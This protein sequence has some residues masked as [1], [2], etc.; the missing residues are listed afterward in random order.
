METETFLIKIDDA[1]EEEQEVF[2]KILRSDFSFKELF[3]LYL[4]A[5]SF[6][7]SNKFYFSEAIKKA[8]KYDELKSLLRRFITL[9]AF[10]TEEEAIKC[11]EYIVSK[12]LHQQLSFN[13]LFDF[14]EFLQKE[15]F[16][17]YEQNEERILVR[18]ASLAKNKSEV[19][20][21]FPFNS[22]TPYF[23]TISEIFLK[24][25]DGDGNEETSFADMF[26]FASSKCIE[27]NDLGFI[28]LLMKWLCPE[29]VDIGYSFLKVISIAMEI[30]ISEKNLEGWLK[31][32]ICEM[33]LEENDPADIILL[34][35]MILVC[36]KIEELQ[37]I[38]RKTLPESI[39]GYHVRSKIEKIKA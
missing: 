23:K 10:K 28:D 18:A 9:K 26:V 17:L 36:T 11:Q 8:E 29:K 35:R 16:K 37:I 2:K 1:T 13:E 7:N 38:E 31:M 4:E 30:P 19:Y 22:N 20:R 27:H 39:P 21:T 34:V 3:F 32:V 6:S 33:D 25:E 24:V 14:K 5:P 12:T 15:Y